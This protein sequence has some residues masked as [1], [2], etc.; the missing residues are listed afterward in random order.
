MESEQNTKKEL[1][2]E[3]QLYILDFKNTKGGDPIEAPEDDWGEIEI[4]SP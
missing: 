1:W 3:P 2:S 4:I